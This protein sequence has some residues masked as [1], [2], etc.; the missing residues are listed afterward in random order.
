MSSLAYGDTARSGKRG[1]HVSQG[2]IA[3]RW[4]PIMSRPRRLDLS[5]GLYLY[6]GDGV[7]GMIRRCPI[8]N[9]IRR[10]AL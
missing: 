1:R 3:F 9:D 7:T 5:G 10:N 6:P 2:N 8:L 4:A